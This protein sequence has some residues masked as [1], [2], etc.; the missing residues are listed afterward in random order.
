[1][2]LP[3][4]VS[5]GRRPG[6]PGSRGCAQL[7]VLLPRTDRIQLGFLLCSSEAG[8][9]SKAAKK[10]CLEKDLFAPYAT[11]ALAEGNSWHGCAWTRWAGSPSII[12]GPLAAAASPSPEGNSS[13][14]ISSCCISR[15]A[16]PALTEGFPTRTPHKP[17]IQANGTRSFSSL[18]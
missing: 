11:S 12:A 8:T 16:P 6:A 5:K 3:G 9:C 15:S 2:M 1:M 14:P 17:W 4:Y 13:S 10:N 18:R 7:L